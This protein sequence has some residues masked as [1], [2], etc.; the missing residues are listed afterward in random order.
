M[1]KHYIILFVVCILL[2]I[3][4]GCNDENNNE[5][6][7]TTNENVKEHRDFYYSKEEKKLIEE[8]FGYF[9]KCDY[10]NMKSYCSQKCIE[11][12]FHDNRVYG[13]VWASLARINYCTDKLIED[14]H[15]ANVYVEMEAAP[16]SSLYGSNGTSFFIM[17]KRNESGKLFIDGFTTV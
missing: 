15:C 11:E 2:C 9:E 13:M 16:E 7:S 4:I 8:F 17:L 1:K 12:Y 6:L 10:E 5:F 14:Y 3:F